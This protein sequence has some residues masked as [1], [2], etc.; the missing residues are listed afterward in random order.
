MSKPNP[1]E[2]GIVTIDISNGPFISP[3][4]SNKGDRTKLY[5][6]RFK[7]IIRNDKLLP[8]L[9][10]YIGIDKVGLL[11]KKKWVENAQY[12]FMDKAEVE[13]FLE[14][15]TGSIPS[16]TKNPNTI[17]ANADFIIKE[18]YFPKSSLF[19]YN[20]K[21]WTIE[22]TT[23]VSC[24]F[25]PEPNLATQLEKYKNR[26]LRK[27]NVQYEKLLTKEIDGITNPVV[28]KSIKSQ[29]DKEFTLNVG[30]LR[31]TVNKYKK[32]TDENKEITD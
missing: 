24:K 4:S 1:N 26:E 8:T 27:L 29:L 2:I 30:K 6:P 11:N 18:I 17:K 23:Y 3:L 19:R 9:Q 32:P 5:I 13:R 16:D 10:K 21:L 14:K 12:L 20:G 25:V 7:S 28:I 15:Y 22:N 31:V